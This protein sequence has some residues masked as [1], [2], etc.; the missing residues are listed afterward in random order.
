MARSKKR[1]D[2]SA[3]NLTEKER[4]RNSFQE[5]YHR[6]LWHPMF[7]PMSHYIHVKDER[8]FPRDGSIAVSDQGMLYASA[9]PYLP[10]G[11]WAYLVAHCLLHLGMEH[12]QHKEFPREWN[13]ACD[14]IVTRFLADLKIFGS[15]PNGV[16]S[17]EIGAGQSE[18]TLYERFCREG[19][20]E[21]LDG[22][23][24]AGDKQIDMLWEESRRRWYQGQEPDWSQLFSAG[25]KQALVEAVDEVGQAYGATRPNHGPAEQARSWFMN[26]FPLLG[27]LAT[28]F[29]IIHDPL[30]CQRMDISVAAVDAEMQ[31]IYINPGAGL[32]D[33]EMLFVMAHELLHVGL[34][35]HARREG[36]E[37]YLWNIACDYVINGWLIEM[38]IGVMPRIGAM[39]DPAFKNES[40]ESIYDRIVGDLR[41][42]QREWTLR[43]KGMGDMLE[44]RKPDWW[45]HGEGL[46]L[47]EFYRRCL[48][49]GLTYHDQYGRGFLPAGLIEEIRALSQP[50]IPWDVELAQWFDRYFPAIEKVRSYARASRRQS[51][52]PDIPRPRWIT[53]PDAEDARTFGV[54]LDTS[55]SMDSRILGKALGAIASYSMARDVPAARVV[56][57]DA[58]AY[59]AGYMPPEAIAGRVQVK[60]RGGTVLQPGIDLLEKAED[61]PVNGP[62]LIITDGMCDVL[63][64][65]REH[66]FLMPDGH[67]LPFRPR[68]PVFKVS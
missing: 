59:D 30:V 4:A 32:S 28:A 53:R 36:R 58:V 51:A 37:P 56:F 19:I 25:L 57:C 8:R 45:A 9:M 31:E 23:G 62:I 52:T 22:F 6:V 18:D 50:P 15:S 44:P 49:Q 20:P 11:D 63:R 3:R 54:V 67:Y 60:G 38:G 17:P 12:F 34:R 13:T 68:G 7:R 27:A 64:I 41:T 16:T 2:K 61:F 33:P 48:G 26:H 21:H 55:G 29:K 42:Y 40:A 24:T 65:K 10:P 1:Q 35:H 14:L 5:G 47:D 39:Y 43:G 66:A 46:S